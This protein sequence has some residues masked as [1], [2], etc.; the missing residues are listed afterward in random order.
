[1]A[2]SALRTEAYF[3]IRPL[4]PLFT[5]ALRETRYQSDNFEFLQ[6]EHKFCTLLFTSYL[7]NA[8]LRRNAFEPFF[9]LFDIVPKANGSSSCGCEFC[10]LPAMF[11][12]DRSE[13]FLKGSVL[14]K[15]AACSFLFDQLL[16]CYSVPITGLK[17]Q[18]DLANYEIESSYLCDPKFLAHLIQEG[19]LKIDIRPNYWQG[20]R[21]NF[22]S[23]HSPGF[24]SEREV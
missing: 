2:I 7:F 17:I 3:S 23:K 24:L 13:G 10:G 1:M 4:P 12:I 19:T 6:D 5:M 8:E 15:Q 22:E 14:I 9:L 18:W 20:I 21:Q 16:P 11:G